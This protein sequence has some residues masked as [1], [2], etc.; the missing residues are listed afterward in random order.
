[1]RNNNYYFHTETI[2]AHTHYYCKKNNDEVIIKQEIDSFKY[3]PIK[4]VLHHQLLEFFDFHFR[5]STETELM[6]SLSPHQ[7]P[8]R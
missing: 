5:L 1:M 3:Y 7:L 8:L 6:Q 2:N 4:T